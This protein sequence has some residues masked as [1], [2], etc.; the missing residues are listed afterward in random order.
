MKV[1]IP[2]A[3]SKH[4]IFIGV[5]SI[6]IGL[7]LLPSSGSVALGVACASIAVGL[8]VDLIVG[9]PAA[10]VLSYLGGFGIS[11]FVFMGFGFSRLLMCYVAVDSDDGS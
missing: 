4:L 7:F 3:S 10:C 11:G 8:G 5:L 9:L 2:N 1:V 6:A